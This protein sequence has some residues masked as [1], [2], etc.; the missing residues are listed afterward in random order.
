M[1]A[2]GKERRAAEDQ[3]EGAP[4]EADV[5]SARSALS[6]TARGHRML[7]DVSKKRK[8]AWRAKK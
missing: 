5:I 2:V 4:R 3:G 6:W 8:P 1:S 7:K